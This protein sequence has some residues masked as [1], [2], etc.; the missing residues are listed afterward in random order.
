MAT[1]KSIEIEGAADIVVQFFECSLHSILYQRGVYPPEDFHVVKKFGINVLKS[2]DD[3][4][5]NYLDEILNQLNTWLKTNT[6]NK[7]VLVIKSKDTQEIVERWQFDIKAIPPGDA[8][9]HDMS[10]C[11]KEIQAILR[12]ITASVS[13]LPTLEEE[14]TFNVLV[15]ANKDVVVPPTWGDS[16]PSFIPGGGEHVK[17]KSLTTSK[18]SIEPFVAYQLRD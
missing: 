11:T 18:H 15:Y 17:L 12:Q 8:I 2:L 16:G 1:D 5:N 7:F 13:F 4:V 3:D 9:A 10:K 14:C 6:L